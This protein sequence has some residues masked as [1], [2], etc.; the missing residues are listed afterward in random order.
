MRTVVFFFFFFFL[1]FTEH[2][3]N[4]MG[5]F[6]KCYSYSEAEK[7]SVQV[8]SAYDHFYFYNLRIILV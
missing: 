6:S 4:C 8:A 2:S 5:M 3:V 7:S 1:P